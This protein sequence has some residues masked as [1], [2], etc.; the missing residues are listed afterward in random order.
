MLVLLGCCVFGLLSVIW[1]ARP[2]SDTHPLDVPKGSAAQSITYECGPPFGSAT[3]EGEHATPYP[4]IGRPCS[5]RQER[6]A[7]AVVD[8]A[9]VLVAV[10]VIMERGRTLARRAASATPA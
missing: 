3:V 5:H 2:W 8:V 9:V 10:V 6:R 1:V 4:V 7:L